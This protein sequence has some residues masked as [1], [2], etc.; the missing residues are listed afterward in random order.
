MILTLYHG[1]TKRALEQIKKEGIR[2][3]D[4]KK[5]NWS[6]VGKSRSDLVYLTTCFACYYACRACKKKGDKAIIIKLKIDSKQIP[7]YAD[8]EF[9]FKTSELCK[10]KNIKQQ[11]KNYDSIDPKDYFE[12]TW[13]E[14]IKHMGTVTAEY[15]SKECLVSYAEAERADNMDFLYYCDPS[16]INPATYKMLHKYYIERINKLKFKKI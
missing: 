11:I 7:L 15:I 16:D 12:D 5:S 8:E 6:G 9:L 4:N 13:E 14:S 3:R 2:P 10:A 1:T